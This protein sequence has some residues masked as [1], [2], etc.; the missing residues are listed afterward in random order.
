MKSFALTLSPLSDIGEE[1]FKQLCD[2]FDHYSWQ[3]IGCRE[4]ASKWHAHFG[5]LAPFETT[6]AF[7]KRIRTLL[8]RF[9][10]KEYGDAKHSIFVTTWY[11]GG[12]GY[13]P[14]IEKCTSAPGTWEEYLTKDGDVTKGKY[15]EYSDEQWDKIRPEVLMSNIPPKDQRETMTWSTMQ[16]WAKLFK[17]NKLPMD[18]MHDIEMG[19]SN[20]CFKA[21]LD[22]MPERRKWN[23]L[24][25]CLWMYMNNYEGNAFTFC[26]DMDVKTTI[27]KKRKLDALTEV[28]MTDTQLEAMNASVS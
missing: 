16:H 26:E 3:W 13:E 24:R 17:E 4:N 12:P 9:D 10:P 14:K 18:T 11:V 22:K 28:R 15:W 20:I 8:H 27:R 2:M 25:D 23:E 21:K 1:T 5:I 7:G 6:S 19:L